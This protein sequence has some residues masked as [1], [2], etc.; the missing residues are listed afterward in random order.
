MLDFEGSQRDPKVRNDVPQILFISRL[1]IIK[2]LELMASTFGSTFRK[3]EVR[4]SISTCI[5]N[6]KLAPVSYHPSV[7]NFVLFF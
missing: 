5:L 1:V 2:G 3:E 7:E 6:F 4:I